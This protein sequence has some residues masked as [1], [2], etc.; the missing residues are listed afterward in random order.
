MVRAASRGVPRAPRYSGMPINAYFIFR[1]RDYHP[2]WCAF[3][4][5][6][7]RLF[8]LKAPTTPGRSL[9]WAVPISLAATHGIDV[10]FFSSR[11]L[12]VSV[13]WVCSFRSMNSTG[14]D[15]LLHQPGFP[16]RT[17]TDQR[18]VTG[19]PW[20]NAGSHV[21]RRFSMPRHPPYT[22][23][24]L[25]TFTDHRHSSSTNTNLIPIIRI[26]V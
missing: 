9:V 1:L 15:W 11:Y 24:S 16:I 25:I 18:L 26:T 14:S 3:P 17:S 20:L 6:S 8:Q 23:S 21:L 5:A 4:N 7:A 2:L 10:S 19:F 22:L 13:P 12:D